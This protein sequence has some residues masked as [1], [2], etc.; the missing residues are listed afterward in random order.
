MRLDR[1]S[2][3]AKQA[4]LTTRRPVVYSS[5][6]GRGK[7]TEPKS[8]AFANRGAG[9][10][11]RGWTRGARETP[12]AAS[13]RVVTEIRLPGMSG[14][15]LCR[16]LQATRLEPGAICDAGWPRARRALE[17]AHRKRPAHRT[18]AAEPCGSSIPGLRAASR[19]SVAAPPGVWRAARLCAPQRRRRERAPRRAVGLL[20][21]PS[22]LRRVSVS[23]AD[24]Q[25]QTGRIASFS[26]TSSTTLA[27]GR[28][29]SILRTG[30]AE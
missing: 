29:V 11:S 20:Q 22:R 23:P 3:R 1:L 18:A 8:P 14:F 4:G 2:A 6:Q 30:S 10:T 27:T 15:D 5:P 7:P 17:C 12:L 21:V 24:T 28:I 9:R 19:A 26:R 25:A 16:L 13:R